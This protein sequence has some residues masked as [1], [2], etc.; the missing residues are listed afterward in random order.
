M[1]VIV[2][3][4]AVIATSLAFIVIPFP[5]PTANVRE[6]AIVPP[7]VNPSPEITDTLE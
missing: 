2:V 1:D 7:P 3:C 6:S 5:A 4:A